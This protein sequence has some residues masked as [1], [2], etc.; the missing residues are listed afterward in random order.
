M[1]ENF[2]YD[3][4]L[5]MSLERTIANKKFNKKKFLKRKHTLHELLMNIYPAIIIYAECS[6]STKNYGVS[7]SSGK[8]RSNS[9]G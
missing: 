8:E 4:T 7:L 9:Y 3:S 1:R 2:S 5:R 6:V